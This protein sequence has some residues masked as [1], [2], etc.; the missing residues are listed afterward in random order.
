MCTWHTEGAVQSQYLSERLLFR[1]VRFLSVAPVRMD[2]TSLDAALIVQFI[3]RVKFHEEVPDKDPPT[4]Q[5]KK[6]FSNQNIYVKDYL[7]P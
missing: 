7:L 6:Q 3:S 2:K 5:I 4:A 1:S